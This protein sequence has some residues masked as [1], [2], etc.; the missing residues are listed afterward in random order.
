L[1]VQEKSA[2]LAFLDQGTVHG[3]GKTILIP[4]G[5]TLLFESSQA[6][7]LFTAQNFQ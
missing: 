1:L 6:A 7:G 5:F 2:P 3:F 4:P